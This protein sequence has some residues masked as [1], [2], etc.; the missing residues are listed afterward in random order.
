[1]QPLLVLPK[2]LQGTSDLGVPLLAPSSVEVEVGVGEGEGKRGW[3]VVEVGVVVL[4]S[5][6]IGRSRGSGLWVTVV[7][8]EDVDATAKASHSAT[9]CLK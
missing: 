5:V 1:M 2:N 9:K 7:V 3:L 4:G 8:V 6:F